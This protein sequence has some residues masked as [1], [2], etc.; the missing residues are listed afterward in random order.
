VLILDT[1]NQMCSFFPSRD[2]TGAVIRPLPKVKKILSEPVL[3]YQIV[4]LLITYDPSIVQRVAT[5][6]N[7]II[8]VSSNYYSINLEYFKG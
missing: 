6:V 7:A 3:L 2:E 4:Q 1:L 5:L 8:Q